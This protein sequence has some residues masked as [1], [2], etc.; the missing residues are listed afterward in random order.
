[1]IFYTWIGY[2]VVLWVL[3][4]VLSNRTHKIVRSSRHELRV[5][6]IIAARNEEKMIAARIENLVTQDYPP[7]LLEIIVGSDGSSDRTVE[8]VNSFASYGVCLFVAPQPIG[9]VAIHNQAVIMAKGDVLIFTDAET[10]FSSNCVSS[11]AGLF[12]DPKVGC[13]SGALVFRNVKESGITRSRGMYWRFEYFLRNL[14]SEIGAMAVASGSCIAVRRSMF[15]PLSKATYDVDFITPFDV[16][17]ADGLVLHHAGAIAEETLFETPRSEFRAQVRMTARNLSGTLE[18]WRVWLPLRRPLVGLSV[19]SHK[20]L[21]WFTPFFLISTLISNIVLGYGGHYRAW[22]AAQCVFYA[23]AAIG[24]VFR[25]VLKEFPVFTLPFSF[26]LSNVAF[27]VGIV[28]AFFGK[29][30]VVYPA[31]H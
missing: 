10:L 25:R 29:P 6:V 2:P 18:R 16:I 4:R 5:S 1:M 8:I 7:H 9:R 23:F 24:F 15:R 27:L 3:S 20:L 28:K 19:V 31:Q 17:E 12:E 11:V 26:C 13:V 22:L 30:I 21:R 14:E